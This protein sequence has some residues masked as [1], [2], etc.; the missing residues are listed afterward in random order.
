MGKDKD[1]N[2][3]SQTPL[4]EHLEELRKRVVYI[5]FILVTVFCF[6]YWRSQFFMDFVTAPLVN[7]MPEGSSMAMLKI[8]EGFLMELK[9]SFIVAL[10]FSMPFIFYHMWRFIAPGLYVHERKYVVGFVISTSLLFFLGAAF[11]YYMVFPFGFAFFLKYAEGYVIANLSIEWYLSFVTKMILAFGIVFELP[12]FT[13]FLAQMG[14]VTADMMRKYRRYSFLGIFI[15][16]AV[17]TPPDVFSQ[18]MMAAPM[19]ILYELS[20]YIAAIFGR[21][22]EVEESVIYE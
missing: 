15:I 18:I 11:A 8:T 10:F 7:V 22:K 20:I 19:L 14:L 3:G 16:A 13:F 2:I 6:C 21:K 9:L 4:I 12:V 5:L 17:L 1:K